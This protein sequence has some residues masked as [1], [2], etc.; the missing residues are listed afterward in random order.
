MAQRVL[1][2][3]THWRSRHNRL[4]FFTLGAA[5][6]LDA[7]RGQSLYLDAASRDNPVLIAEFGELQRRLREVLSEALGCEVEWIDSFA[8]PGF[9][10][11]GACPEFSAPFAD[12]HVDRQHR[13]LHFGALA[14]V[15]E[16]NTLSITLPLLL[17]T[18]GA[19]LRLWNIDGRALENTDAATR[20]RMTM[21]SAP[22]T[23][24]HYTP[25]Q[26]LL[27]DG[28]QLHQIAPMKGAQ[29]GEWRITLQAHAALLQG[30]WRLYW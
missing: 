22:P 9:H 23:V 21:T 4:P 2:L 16:S 7:R 24:E 3:R 17:P 25:G 14:P 6:Y 30:R 13:L 15:D 28:F 27:H 20:S 1:G 19:G 10:V 26:A 12:I 29:P 8:L 5:S 11:F 18:G